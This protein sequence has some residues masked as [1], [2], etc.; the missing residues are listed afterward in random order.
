MAQFKTDNYFEVSISSQPG[1]GFTLRLLPLGN[2]GFG[3]I[4]PMSDVQPIEVVITDR[5]ARLLQRYGLPCH[6]ETT[7]LNNKNTQS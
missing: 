2:N 1:V 6:Y 3:L 4:A 7:F 5:A